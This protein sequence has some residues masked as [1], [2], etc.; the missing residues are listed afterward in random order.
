MRTGG[1]SR[2]CGARPPSRLP[3]M[4]CGRMIRTMIRT[5]NPTAVFRPGSMNSVDISVTRPSTIPPARAP[6]A[7]PMPPRTTAAKI[8]S[9]SA[10]PSSGLR[11]RLAAGEHARQPG[12]HPGE[13]PGV[14]DHPR[15]VDAASSRPGRGRP[16]APASAC[17]ASSSRSISP[18]ATIT[19]TPIAIVISCVRPIVQAEELD[20]RGGVRRRAHGSRSPRRTGSPRGSGTPA[21]S[22]SARAGAGRHGACASAPT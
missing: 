10:K 11:L 19:T 21:R 7:S 15:G 12:Q 17:R 14:E 3:K 5:T 22:T 13:Q 9:R 8:G 1:R 4:P 6:N 2:A 18:T 16:R 20:G